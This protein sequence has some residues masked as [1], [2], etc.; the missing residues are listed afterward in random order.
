MAPINFAKDIYILDTKY[1][2]DQVIDVL[3]SI[4]ISKKGKKIGKF[5]LVSYFD[6][7]YH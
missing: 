3:G 5:N 2:F 1:I 6:I 4:F 7:D